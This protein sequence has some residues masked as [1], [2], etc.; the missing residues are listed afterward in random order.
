[1]ECVIITCV[2]SSDGS[3]TVSITSYNR[4]NIKEIRHL[5]NHLNPGCFGCGSFRLGCFGL[6][7]FGLI[8]G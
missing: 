5:V 2:I 6:G 4:K 7:R 3:D 8:L 1:M